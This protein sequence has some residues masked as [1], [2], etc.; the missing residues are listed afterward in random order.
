MARRPLRHFLSDGGARADRRSRAPEP[1][2]PDSAPA[3]IA[4]DV[5]MGRPKI[6]FTLIFGGLNACVHYQFRTTSTEHFGRRRT[7]WPAFGTRGSRLRTACRCGRC[8]LMTMRFG[9]HAIR[10]VQDLLVDAA[11]AHRPR[12]PPGRA[13]PVSWTNDGER[14][15]RRPCRCCPLEVGRYVFGGAS[16]GVSGSTLTKRIV[17]IGCRRHHQRKSATA[18]LGPSPDPRG[19]SGN[20]DFSCTWHRPSL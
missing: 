9:L 6:G 17:P 8:E 10:L 5:V 3:V 16:P 18:G 4:G 1:A 14:V 7:T 15:F 20:Q 11:L 2:S 13:K 19:R 12:H